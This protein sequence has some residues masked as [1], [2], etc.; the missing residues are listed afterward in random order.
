MYLWARWT[1]SNSECCCMT[2]L[3]ATEL[4]SVFGSIHCDCANWRHQSTAFGL[5]GEASEQPAEHYDTEENVTAQCD[6]S[7]EHRLNRHLMLQVALSANCEIGKYENKSAISK[8][9]CI[10]AV[11]HVFSYRLK[12]PWYKTHV[13]GLLI[14]VKFAIWKASMLQSPKTCRD[15]QRF[16]LFLTLAHLFVHKI[17]HSELF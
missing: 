16:Q 13:F 14:E 7:K 4:S 5:P 1:G 2:P 15:A 6:A 17:W 11:T 3:E 9:R 12:V 8:R 10:R